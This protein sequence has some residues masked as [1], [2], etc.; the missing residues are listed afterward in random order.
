[1][2]S[3]HNCQLCWMFKMDFTLVFGHLKHCCMVALIF[4]FSFLFSFCLVWGLIPDYY[5]DTLF[6][7]DH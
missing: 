4:F 7:I 6:E 1:M 3:H 5:R 2:A